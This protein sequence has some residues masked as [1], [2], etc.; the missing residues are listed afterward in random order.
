MPMLAAQWG[1]NEY[2]VVF[3]ITDIFIQES[4]CWETRRQESLNGNECVQCSH[5]FCFAPYFLEERP[6]IPATLKD[7]AL[8][9]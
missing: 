6:T 7:R 3:S 4:I 1:H 9:F 2:A 8:L 5:I